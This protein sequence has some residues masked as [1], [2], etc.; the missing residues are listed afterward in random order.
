MPGRCP[1]CH[2]VKPQNAVNA[3]LSKTAESNTL[4]TE[5]ALACAW[6]SQVWNGTIPALGRKPDKN[7]K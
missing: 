4:I 5:G 6:G 1:V 7:K 3:M 2:R